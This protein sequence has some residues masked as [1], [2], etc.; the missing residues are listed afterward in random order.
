MGWEIE[1]AHY[2][3]EHGP[4]QRIWRAHLDAATPAHLLA[5]VAEAISNPA[6]VLRA[7]FKINDSAHLMQGP[8]FAIGS[9]VVSAHKQ[10]LAETRRHRPKP[11]LTTAVTAPA[12]PRTA[13][14]ARPAR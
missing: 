10:R 8:E 2:F 14:P 13:A 5:A 11:H 3:G 1:A 4:E 7:R 6:P 12:L 9:E